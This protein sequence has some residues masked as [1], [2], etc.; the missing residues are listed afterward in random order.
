MAESCLL[1]KYFPE[2]HLKSPCSFKFVSLKDIPRSKLT[3]LFSELGCLQSEFESSHCISVD[4]IVICENHFLELKNRDYN[5]QRSVKCMLPS[6]LA[7]H[8]DSRKQE[9]RLTEQ[10]VQQIFLT[11]GIV[12]PI[13][14]GI[15]HSCR[16][17]VLKDNPNAV[18]GRK[19]SLT[20]EGSVPEDTHDN[21]VPLKRARLSETEVTSSAL[22]DTDSEFQVSQ[23]TVSQLSQSSEAS[24]SN[25]L[26]LESLN[27]FQHQN[28]TTLYQQGQT[29]H[30]TDDFHNMSWGRGFHKKAVF[31]DMSTKT[32]EENATLETLV[33]I[34]KRA[35]SWT[36]QRQILTTIV[37]DMELQD[38]QKL[39]PG[40]TRYKFNQAKEHIEQFGVG[41]PVTTK[42]LSREK[43][44]IV[45]DQPFGEKTLK[46]E[47]GE[48]IIIPTVIRSLTPSSIISQY[49]ALCNEE[50]VKPLDNKLMVNNIIVKYKYTDVEIEGCNV[51]ESSAPGNGK[52]ETLT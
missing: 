46:M 43:Y 33:E 6:C 15:C 41:E 35:D 13:G 18:Q 19:L 25:S 23:E 42:K 4:N 17:E 27:K 50:N 12:L 9:R 28:P 51:Y 22:D 20:H 14:T 21:A 45:K 26:K 49:V 52:F 38:V 10:N 36:F 5:R 2:F 40:L 34:Y 24:V 1:P 39:I 48:V 7:V 11:T 37:K 44:T 31:N 30:G 3:L 29:M 16:V 8:S 47:T 32:M